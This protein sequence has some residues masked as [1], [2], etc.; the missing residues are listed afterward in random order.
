MAGDGTGGLFTHMSCTTDR[1]GVS[2]R[3]RRATRG[4]SAVL[5]LVGLAGLVGPPRA[6]AQDL[7]QDLGQAYDAVATAYAF[8]ATLTN[9]SLPLAL[10][11]E[12]AG[13]ASQAHLS[14]LQ[15]SDCF[16]SFP[17][18]GPV[19]T[20]LPELARS[21]ILP[22]IPIPDYPTYAATSL[23]DPPRSI[24]LPGIDLRAESRASSCVSSAIAGT[25]SSGLTAETRTVRDDDGTVTATGRTDANVVRVGNILTLTGFHS[26]A[27]AILRAD[28][29]IEHSS[30]LT[31]AELLVPGLSI[32]IPKTTPGSVPVPVPIPG[33]PQIGSIALPPI[34][35]PFGGVTID[36][37][38]LGIENGSFTITLPFLGNQKFALPAQPVFDALDALGL[39]VQFLEA[40]QTAT[41]VVSPA[42]QVRMQLPALP[43][44]QFF[45]GPT[46]VTYAFGRT[47]AEITGASSVPA[48]DGDLAG[49]PDPS[50][51]AFD[52]PA[53]G[54]TSGPGGFDVGASG[55]PA[56][57]PRS[58]PG[59]P[60]SATLPFKSA[61]SFYFV[62]V[63]VGFVGTLGSQSIRLLGMLTP[64]RS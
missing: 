1:A 60:V 38:R 36:T 42:F 56:D 6:D 41:K 4:A 2:R 21:A 50:G 23:G 14:S 12:A 52:L 62:F 48:L 49:L 25:A 59:A 30:D 46:D 15:Q 35:L 47:T 53:G 29:S 26:T 28:G 45:N 55:P 10:V 8:D 40:S 20:G 43:E 32:T 57:G 24:S 22:G 44:N 19:V 13:P 34:P 17:Y 51:T 11:V 64:W 61:S 3:R 18:P 16:A 33:L 54:G 37:P 58:V 39:D 63:A 9:P 7:G 5:L 31:I 27:T